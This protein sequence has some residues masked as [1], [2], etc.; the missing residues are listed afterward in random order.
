MFVRE[1]LEKPSDIPTI[2][3]DL[4]FKEIE[5]KL[6]KYPKGSLSR[7]EVVES[8][9]LDPMMTREEAEKLCN[10]LNDEVTK[11]ILAFGEKI[12]SKKTKKST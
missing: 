9:S 11:T 2:D 4:V 5:K 8:F 3:M 6:E 7:R 10:Q 12:K 1:V